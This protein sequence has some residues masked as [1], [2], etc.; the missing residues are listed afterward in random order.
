[1][2]NFEHLSSMSASER[3]SFYQEQDRQKAE[4]AERVRKGLA[5]KFTDAEASLAHYK[6]RL[7]ERRRDGQPTSMCEEKIAEL[8]RVVKQEAQQ[9][10]FLESSGAKITLDAFE[11]S[12]V[13]LTERGMSDDQRIQLDVARKIWESNHDS[14]ALY[15]QVSDVA[16]ELDERD[17]ALSNEMTADIKDR[18]HELLAQQ[19][20]IQNQKV[21]AAE[22]NVPKPT[23]GE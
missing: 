7:V 19:V 20:E 8:H 3:L 6:K 4:I 23:T 9:Q 16:F 2:N 15:S 21:R 11:K 13:K 18:E 17:R 14:E 22:L 12:L 10:T 1:M 5:P